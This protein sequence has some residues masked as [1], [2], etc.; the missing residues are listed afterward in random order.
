MIGIYKITSP[1]NHIYVGQ[2]WDISRRWVTYKK[3]LCKGQPRL[4]HSLKKYQPSSHHFEILEVVE[5]Q[6][7]QS[8]LDDRERYYWQY[9]R[10]SGYVMLNI[11]EPGSTG[12]HSPESK[13]KIAET[14]QQ[15]SPRNRECIIDGCLYISAHEASRKL[16]IPHK[17]IDYRLKCEN[18]S[19][20]SYS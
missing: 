12:K 9:Y 17:T 7:N 19:N 10:D 5:N 18:F 14:L 15:K 13:Q 6:V 2:S 4:L 20:Y 8:L 3:L 16:N 1:T 11:K